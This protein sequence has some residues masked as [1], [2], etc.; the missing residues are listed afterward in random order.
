MLFQCIILDAL[1]LPDADVYKC[2]L[3]KE[4]KIIRHCHDGAVESEIV[5]VGNFTMSFSL[6]LKMLF[7]LK[8]AKS[9]QNSP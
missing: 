1:E 9:Y 6:S 8:T 5:K 3:C 2:P 7:Y 4:Y